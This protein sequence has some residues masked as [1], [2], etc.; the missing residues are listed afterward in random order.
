MKAIAPWRMLALLVARARRSGLSDPDAMAL[1]TTGRGGRPA[2]RM[3]LLRGIDARGLL[4]YTN[5]QSRKGQEIARI[6]LA[7][8][9][10]YWPELARQVRIEGRVRRLSPAESDRYFAA[11]PR[12]AQLAAWASGQSTPIASRSVLLAHYR[13]AERRFAGRNVE[14]PVGWGGYLLT[15]RVF[16]FWAA[17][18]HRLH[19]RMRYTRRPGGWVGMR[20]A[21]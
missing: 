21:P 1:A 19:D 14:R 5:Y 10:L 18:E 13:E 20:L 2:V 16:E 12:G 6:P 4:F 11:R 9:V 17:G 8:A 7:A 3:V 15:P